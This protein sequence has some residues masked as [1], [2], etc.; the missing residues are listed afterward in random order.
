MGA[1]T[2]TIAVALPE[3]AYAIEIGE[4]VLARVGAVLAGQGIGRVIVVTNATIAAHWLAP[5]NAG[6]TAASIASQSILVPDGEEHKT[7]ATLDAVKPRLSGASQ[8]AAIV[9]LVT[10]MARRMPCAAS[11]APTRAN[12]PS[13]ISIA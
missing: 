12:T 11:A 6:L 13:P 7:L 4:G 10:T 9:A 5:L 8:C 1:A 3:R 2:T